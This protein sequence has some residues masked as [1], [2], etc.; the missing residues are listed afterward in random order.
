MIHVHVAA[1][2][3]LND[4]ADNRNEILYFMLDQTYMKN[5]TSSNPSAFAIFRV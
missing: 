1:V 5:Y 4:A 3:N 2:K